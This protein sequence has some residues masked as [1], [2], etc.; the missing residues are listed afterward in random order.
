MELISWIYSV[1]LPPLA[2]PVSQGTTKNS[3]AGQI[4]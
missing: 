4:D 1:A 2:S 3:E